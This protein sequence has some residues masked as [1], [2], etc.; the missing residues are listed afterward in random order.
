VRGEISLFATRN[1][2]GSVDSV[3]AML[4]DVT[5]RYQAVEALAHSE[6]R[7][8]ALTEDSGDVTRILDVDGTIRYASASQR[9][10]LGVDPQAVIGHTSFEFMDPEVVPAAQATLE[11]VVRTGQSR[12]LMSR[13]LHVDGTYHTFE[14]LM[15]NR[16]DDPAVR[17]IVINSRDVTARV[18]AEAAL[19]A[20]EER[21]RQVEQHAPI[22]LA[23][24][25]PDGRW[26]RVNPALCALVGYA[27]DELLA[28]T[29]QEITH[30]DDLAADRAQVQGLLA[31]DQTVAR[32]EQRYVRKDT[33]HVWVLLASS[34]VRDDD[35]RPQYVITQV[36]DVTDRKSTERALEQARSAAETLAHM[37]S[38]FVARVSHELRTP[39]TAIIGFGELL[40]E[41]WHQ[42]SEVRRLERIEQIVLAA[43]RQQRLVEDLLLVSRLEAASLAI[44][45][46]PVS[47]RALVQQ[48]AG[49]LQ[50]SYPG[51]QVVAKGPS[52]VSMWTDAGRAAQVLTNLIDNAA[53][54]SPEGSAIVVSWHV[55]HQ[56]EVVVRVRD[57]GPGIAETGRDQLFTRF[58]RITGSRIRAGHVGTGLG[59]Y[60]SRGLAEVM[61]GDLDLECSGP[62]GST[63]RLRLP[64]A[65]ADQAAMPGA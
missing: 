48:I 22:G 35:G 36:Q 5:E 21:Y 13:T 30:P 10:I 52:D 43:H 50:V 65:T 42:F 1:A 51:Q 8:R 58:G 27:E 56:R 54:Y 12:R 25:A 15:H 16:L 9:V 6:A 4:L 38:D 29:A 59:L 55:E 3:I 53:K 41:H 7:F 47:V 17:G 26:L 64:A 2:A 46:V 11:E 39:L 62:Q 24:M 44:Q 33:S 57:Q 34:V 40:R 60:I 28:R 63:F 19:R 37:Q 23:L 61:G 14:A 32:W 18:D 45:Y 49:E 31:G 20:S